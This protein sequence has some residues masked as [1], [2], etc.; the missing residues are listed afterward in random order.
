MFSIKKMQGAVAVAVVAGLV[1][2][3]LALAK[4]GSN[5]NGG[6]HHMAGVSRPVMVQQSFKT[7][8]QKFVKSQTTLSNQFTG[9][10]TNLA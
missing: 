10:N 7:A 5:N 6:S 2:P 4:S 9:P 1:S 3:Q 8:P